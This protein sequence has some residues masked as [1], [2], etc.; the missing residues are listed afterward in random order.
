MRIGWAEFTTQSNIPPSGRLSLRIPPPWTATDAGDS[1]REVRCRTRR[2]LRSSGRERSTK[3]ARLSIPPFDSRSESECR[4]YAI[5]D[6]TDGSQPRLH[7][8]IG[9]LWKQGCRG[10]ACERYS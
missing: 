5:D 8:L 10:L 7:L 3:T 2:N 1:L 6:D 4:F 9:Y